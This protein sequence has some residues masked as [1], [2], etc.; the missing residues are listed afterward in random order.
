MNHE[1]Y[2]TVGAIITAISVGNIAGGVWGWLMLGI[3]C[4]V[5]GI[6]R[7]VKADED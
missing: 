1:Y 3:T 6:C 7:Y 4:I 5:A 2:F